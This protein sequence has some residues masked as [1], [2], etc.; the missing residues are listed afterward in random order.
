MCMMITQGMQVQVQR[1]WECFQTKTGAY[2][3]AIQ[4]YCEAIQDHWQYEEEGLK[5]TLEEKLLGTPED[6]Y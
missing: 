3:C 1:L 5:D 6:V 4:K 2:K